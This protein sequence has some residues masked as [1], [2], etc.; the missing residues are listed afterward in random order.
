[1][2]AISSEASDEEI[3][4]AS[5]KNPELFRILVRRY[6]APF[7][8]KASA[9]LRVPEDAEEVVQDTFTRIYL[10]AGRYQA[11]EGAVFSSWAYTILT[12]LAFTRYQRMKKR[13]ATIEP[14]DPEVYESLRDHDDFVETLTIRDEALSALAKLPEAMR[15]VLTLQFLEGKSQEEIAKA[16]GSTVP[17]IKTRVHRAKKLLK[18]AYDTNDGN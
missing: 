7:L 14:L 9:I 3:L 1:M 8:R 5:A 17:A 2:S 18:E 13:R 12:R 10:Y 15:R 6:E 11:Q 16:E 4:R